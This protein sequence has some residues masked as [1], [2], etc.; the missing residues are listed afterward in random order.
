MG[1]CHAELRAQV[2]QG[3]SLHTIGQ[4]EALD[5]AI[6]DATPLWS[7][8]LTGQVKTPFDLWR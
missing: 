7:N 3:D 2:G 5:P 8:N 4:R 1:S 6:H